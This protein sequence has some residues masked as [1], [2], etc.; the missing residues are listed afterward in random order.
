MKTLD[1]VTAILLAVGGL[2]WGLVG[3]FDFNLVEFVF[4]QFP[5]IAKLIYALVGGAAV[6]QLFQWK[7][8]KSCCR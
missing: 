5:A 8:L 2:N 6:Y 1:I 7:T 3:L 4:G